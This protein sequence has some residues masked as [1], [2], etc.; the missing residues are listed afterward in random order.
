MATG[1]QVLNGMDSIM[2]F[3]NPVSCSA[4]PKAKPP[5]TIQSTLQLISSRS[6][7][8]MMPVI[9][10]TAMGSIATT[11]ELTPVNLSDIHSSTV[12]AKVM[13]T[14]MERQSF[15]ASPSIFSSM[16][17]CLKGNR[18]SRMNQAMNSTMMV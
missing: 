10:N 4:T 11:F 9:Q 14:K 8:V 13:Y 18:R 6:R 12:T 5:D 16:V 2:C 17:F 1:G 3:A 15:F 7:L